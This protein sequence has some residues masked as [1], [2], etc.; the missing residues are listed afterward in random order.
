MLAANAL[1][2]TFD[3][4]LLTWNPIFKALMGVTQSACALLRRVMSEC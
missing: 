4:F 1:R 2:W 3:E